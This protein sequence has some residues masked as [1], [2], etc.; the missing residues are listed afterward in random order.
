MKKNKSKIFYLLIYY[1][2]NVLRKSL[3]RKLPAIK[4][5]KLKNFV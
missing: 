1:L 2:I 3:L 4:E 5:G